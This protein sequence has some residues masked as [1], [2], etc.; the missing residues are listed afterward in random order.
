MNTCYTRSARL[1]AALTLLQRRKLFL[2]RRGEAAGLA[3][4]PLVLLVLAALTWS[5]GAA[6]AQPFGTAAWPIHVLQSGRCL[7]ADT[8]TI[9]TNGTKVQ[10]WDC[11]GG[12]NQQWKMN[13]DGTVVNLQ[14]GRCLDADTG[15]IG[16]N[17]ARMQLWD[18]WG[19]KNQKWAFNPNGSLTSVQSAQCLD[20]DTNTIGGNGTVVQLW[21]CNGSANQRWWSLA[22]QNGWS[23]QVAQSGRCL[24]ADLNTIVDNGTVV[25]LWDCLS[26]N[27][28][29]NQSW[30]VTPNGTIVNLQSHRCLDAD[31]GSIGVN[32]TKMQLWDCWG[33]QNQNWNWP[34]F[35]PG[36]GIRGSTIT[37]NQSQQCLDADS[38]TIGN[39]GTKVQLWTCLGGNNPP[40]NQFWKNPLVLN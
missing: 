20:A 7:D 2:W 35:A 12:Q 21:S 4:V 13:G 22:E 40:L 16:A 8:G 19:G 15:T 28:N 30:R 32:G 5:G 14:S 39:N 31:L 33:G 9:G 23:I 10:L 6:Q 11:W 38:N 24:D 29:Q 36:T 26:N 1:I 37:S 27:Q 34:G 18:C 17:G 25:Q 3:V